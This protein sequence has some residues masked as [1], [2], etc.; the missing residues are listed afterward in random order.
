MDQRIRHFLSSSQRYRVTLRQRT[1]DLF[2]VEVYAWDQTCPGPPDLDAA[3]W[4][5]IAGPIWAD[6]SARAE[7]LVSEE[8]RSF[9]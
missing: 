1:R 7:Q 9:P 2:T 3:G 5:R 4:Q 6:G 8:L